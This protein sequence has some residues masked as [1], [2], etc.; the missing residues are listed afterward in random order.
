VQLARRIVEREGVL[1]LWR[2]TAATMLSLAPNSAI[3]WLTHEECKPRLAR[4]LALSEESPWL[5][6]ISGTA[7]GLSSTLATNPLDVVKTRLQCAEESGLSLQRVLRGVLAEAGWRGLYHGLIPRLAAAVPRSIA[8]VL[9][10][11]QSI[12]LCRRPSA[13]DVSTGAQVRPDWRV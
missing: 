7:A 11:E 12:A 10:Y 5:L 3:W 9:F 8:A 2:G 13:A 1:G 4:K 6:A